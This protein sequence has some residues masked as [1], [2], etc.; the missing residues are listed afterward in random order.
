MAEI[1]RKSGRR[2]IESI[3]TK[4]SSKQEVFDFY[5]R[6]RAQKKRAGEKVPPMMKIKDVKKA[7]IVKQLEV[8]ERAPYERKIEEKYK[9]F[10]ETATA[11][12]PA[13]AAKEYRKFMKDVQ[14]LQKSKLIDIKSVLGGTLQTPF[15]E[16]P[17]PIPKGSA[18][19]AAPAPVPV[20]KYKGR[21]AHDLI[22]KWVDAGLID[23]TDD[24]DDSEEIWEFLAD[25]TQKAEEY[26]FFKANYQGEEKT[27]TNAYYEQFKEFLADAKNFE[28]D[29]RRKNKTIPPY[30]TKEYWDALAAWREEQNARPF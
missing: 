15:E 22:K 26:D 6:F 19:A 28:A 17:K 29:M 5:K 27:G 8:W 14:L 9:A 18:A 23:N 16:K 2:I 3:D 30:G 4:K 10:Q 24:Y 12:A 1:S 13:E 11:K 20:P 7:D 21:F 25:S